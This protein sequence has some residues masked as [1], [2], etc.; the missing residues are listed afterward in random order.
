MGQGFHVE[1]LPHGCGDLHA[2][3][4]DRLGARDAELV[5]A[6]VV[7]ALGA[8]S[9]VDS[10]SIKIDLRRLDRGGGSNERRLAF[11]ERRVER[12][13]KLHWITMPEHMHVHREGLVAQEVIV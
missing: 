5:D 10:G 4:R 13:R 1:P 8:K 3:I 6:A 9:L 7:G 2:A 12:R 11:G